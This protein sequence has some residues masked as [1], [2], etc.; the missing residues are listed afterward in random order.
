M[1]ALNFMGGFVASMGIVLNWSRVYAMEWAILGVV[2]V[3]SV[4]PTVV[5]AARMARKD[6]VSN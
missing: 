2:F 5:L 1:V 6:G 3:I 4:F